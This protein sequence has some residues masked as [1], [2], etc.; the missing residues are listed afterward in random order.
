MPKLICKFENKIFLKE[1]SS[2]DRQPLQA[3]C[4]WFRLCVNGTYLP[5]K[6][7]SLGS[8]HKQMFNPVTKNCTDSIKLS[9]VGQCQTYKK[10]LVIDSVSPY[11]KWTEFSCGPGQHFDQENQECIDS[12][13][14]TCGEFFHVLFQQ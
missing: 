9:V 1:C 11:G 8:T 6:C 7:A 14:S 3:E 2:G 4:E 13:I 10:C 12:D 5:R